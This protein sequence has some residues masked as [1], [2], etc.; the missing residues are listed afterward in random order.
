ML[1]WQTSMAEMKFDIIT[2]F[3]TFFASFKNEALMARAQE[4]K[5]ISINTYFL[6]DYTDDAHHTVDGRP[7]GGGAGMVLMVEPILKAVKDIKKQD[8]TF[9]QIQ[10][11][12]LKKT[13]TI[14]FSPKG[15]KFDQAV[16]RRWS[17]LDQ[18]IMICGRYEG[19]D[20][21]VAQYIADEEVSIGDYVLFGGEVPAMVVMEAVTRLIPGALGKLE[22]LKEES[23]SFKPI[24]NNQQPTTKLEYPHYTRPE[25]FDLNGKK[26]GVPKV[27]LSGNHKKIEKWRKK[28]SS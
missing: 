7:Y 9:F 21:R 25:F 27:L 17:K 3:P 1:A 5:L 13:R 8:S 22:S 20:E 14:V 23:F 10:G 15:K 26:A 4:K 16:A 19:I 18:L 11:R 6:R 12:I 2:I 24:A 28:H